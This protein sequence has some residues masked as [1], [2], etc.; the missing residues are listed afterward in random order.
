MPT[1]NAIATKDVL[2]NK[3]AKVSDSFNVNVYDN[4]FMLEIAGRD[5]DSEW[6]NAKII[7]ANVAELVDLI[8]AITSMPKDE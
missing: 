1:K 4:G 7:C 3:L 8:Q 2:T 5:S 6:K